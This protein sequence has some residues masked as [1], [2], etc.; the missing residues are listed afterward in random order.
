[1]S[2][3]DQSSVNDCLEELERRGQTQD[4]RPLDN[5]DIFGDYNVAYTST[6]RA[7]RQSGQ[8]E[9]IFAPKVTHPHSSEIQSRHSLTS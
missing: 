9:C 8:R 5:S 3:Q 6:Q 4:P 1:M 7:P 2:Q